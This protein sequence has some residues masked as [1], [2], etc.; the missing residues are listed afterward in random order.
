MLRVCLLVGALTPV[1][2]TGL[3]QGCNLKVKHA[4]TSVLQEGQLTANKQEMI[5]NK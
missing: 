5:D 2:Y 1:N 3:Y 4:P